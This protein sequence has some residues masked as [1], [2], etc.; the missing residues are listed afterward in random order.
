[1]PVADGEPCQARHANGTAAPAT[2]P[3]LRRVVVELTEHTPVHD[4]AALRRHCDELRMRGALIALELVL[5]VRDHIVS[6]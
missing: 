3:D 2:R 4:L 5:A 1:M 6:A